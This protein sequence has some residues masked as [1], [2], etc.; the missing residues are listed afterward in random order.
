MQTLHSCLEVCLCGACALSL[1]KTTPAVQIRAS[2]VAFVDPKCTQSVWREEKS[3]LPN[4]CQSA[5]A[6]ALSTLSPLVA[7]TGSPSTVRSYSVH[8]VKVFYSLQARLR[9]EET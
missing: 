5:L 1:A 6:S 2:R 4:S 8:I 9:T 3:T 7:I